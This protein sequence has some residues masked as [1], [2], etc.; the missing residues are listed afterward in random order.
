[1][2]YHGLVART[3]K[4]FSHI[5]WLEVW[6][7][8]VKRIG[9]FRGL[10]PWFVDGHLFLCLYIVSSI[11]ICVQMSFSYKD[12]GHIGLGFTLMTSF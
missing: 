6:D 1:M 12:I 11:S 2:K 10:I 9:P 3:E 7:Q 8:G 4:Y 5:W